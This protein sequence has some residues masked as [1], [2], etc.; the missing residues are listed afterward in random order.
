MVISKNLVLGTFFS[1][2]NKDATEPNKGERTIKSAN[3]N[4][5]CDESGSNEG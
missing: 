4:E 2:L 1:F 3:E 5:K